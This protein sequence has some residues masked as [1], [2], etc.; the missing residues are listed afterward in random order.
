MAD[1][2]GLRDQ[3]REQRCVRMRL[4]K[5]RIEGIELWMENLLDTGKIDFSVLSP[6]MVPV[7]QQRCECQK[8]EEEQVFRFQK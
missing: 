2:D 1:A 6:G 8:Q 4:K 7:D 5:L 3:I